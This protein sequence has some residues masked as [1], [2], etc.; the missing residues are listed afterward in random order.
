MEGVTSDVDDEQWR[1]FI[2]NGEGL[3]TTSDV[4]SLNGM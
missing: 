2:N 1:G 3:T 4:N